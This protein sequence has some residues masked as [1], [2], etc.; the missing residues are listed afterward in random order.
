MGEEVITSLNTQIPQSYRDIFH[1]LYKE[2]IIDESVMQTMSSLVYYRNRL[3]HQYSGLDSE[4]LK[5]IMSKIDTI[6]T[7]IALLKNKTQDTLS[8]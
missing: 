8:N 6:R 5:I 7:Y 3:A 2:Q 1:I 4:D